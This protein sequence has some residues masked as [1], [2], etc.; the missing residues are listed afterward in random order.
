MSTHST[1]GKEWARLSQLRRGDR[2]LTDDGFTCGI[3]NKTLTVEQ[4]AHGFFVPCDEGQHFLDGQLS[5]EDE[6][7]LIGMWPAATT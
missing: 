1:D 7:H 3:N 5:D 4:N 2:V 6:D